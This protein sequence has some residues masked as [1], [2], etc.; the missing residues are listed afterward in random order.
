MILFE[1]VAD[2]PELYELTN[3]DALDKACTDAQVD[4]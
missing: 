3:K 1:D 4:Y 2:P